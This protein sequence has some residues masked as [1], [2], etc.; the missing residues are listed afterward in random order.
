MGRHCGVARKGE[1]HASKY[2]DGHCKPDDVD[3]T[4]LE[5]LR[6]LGVGNNMPNCD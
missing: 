1:Q 6:A 2:H 3:S 4:Q 5:E